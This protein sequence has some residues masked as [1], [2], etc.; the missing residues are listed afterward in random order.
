MPI[1]LGAA[2]GHIARETRRHRAG[3]LSAQRTH[4]QRHHGRSRPQDTRTDGISW[5]EGNQAP[6]HHRADLAEKLCRQADLPPRFRPLP[7]KQDALGEVHPNPSWVLGSRQPGKRIDS[8]KRVKQRF[9]HCH[10]R[11]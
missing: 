5:Q 9:L 8:C 10:T 6:L 7:H 2:P 4:L 1:L 11:E 3:G